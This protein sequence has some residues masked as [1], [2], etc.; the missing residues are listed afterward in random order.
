MPFTDASST[1][2][3][4][5]VVVTLHGELDVTE[6][7]LVARAL[8]AAAAPGSQIIVDL[9]GLAFMDCSARAAVTEVQQ[10]A[11]RAGGDLVL[12]APQQLVARL[13]SLIDPAR[14][15]PV[16]AGVDEAANGIGAVSGACLPG[17]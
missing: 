1:L 15:L 4:G 11:R 6:A 8:S 5:Y 13:L 17:S 14:L 7:A 9:A 2:C 16:F 12:A 3:P 10:Q